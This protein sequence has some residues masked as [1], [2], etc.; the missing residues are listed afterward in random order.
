MPYQLC[1]NGH[2]YDS[3]K[4]T[5]CQVCGLAAEAGPD[6]VLPVD[7]EPSEPLGKGGFDPPVGWLVVIDG[8]GKG[9]GFRIRAGSNRI[10]RDEGMEIALI[11]DAA[12]SRQGHA[13]VDFDANSNRF[14]AKAGEGRELCY[15]NGGPVAAPAGL[16]RFDRLR[17]GKTTLLFVPLVSDRFQW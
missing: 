10:G 15:L 2:Y 9:Q 16:N 14:V 8:P 1:P 13:I 3:G 17:V 5:R 11:S 7:P 12:V 4:D 6:S